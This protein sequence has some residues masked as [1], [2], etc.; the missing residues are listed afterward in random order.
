[1]PDPETLRTFAAI[2]LAPLSVYS[3]RIAPVWIPDGALND[4]GPVTEGDC[5]ELGLQVVVVLAG[6]CIQAANLHG[7]ISFDECLCIAVAS[8]NDWTVVT[9]NAVLERTCR[10]ESVRTSSSLGI[11]RDLLRLS[12]IPKGIARQVARRVLRRRRDTPDGF[13]SFVEDLALVVPG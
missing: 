11:L 3:R 6:Q 10:R 8:E 13:E 5:N 9:D 12:L 2:S 7:D 1:M 4:D